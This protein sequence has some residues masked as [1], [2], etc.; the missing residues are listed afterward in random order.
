MTGNELRK[1]I[2]KLIL[3]TLNADDG[4]RGKKL[5]TRKKDEPFGEDPIG[6]KDYHNTMRLDGDVDSIYNSNK[7]K[8]L[9]RKKKKITVN[10]VKVKPK[11]EPE[12]L[13]EELTIEDYAKI[14]KLVRAT[15]A[16]VLFGLWKKRQMWV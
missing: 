3:E 7:K 4:R 2:R 10:N 6:Q 15:V 8:H 14:E 13:D 16:D 1:E 12:E 9:A 5:R 11:L